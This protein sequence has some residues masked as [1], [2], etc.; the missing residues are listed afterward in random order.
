MNEILFRPW[1]LLV[2]GRIWTG[3][4]KGATLAN[5]RSA[6]KNWLEGARTSEQDEQLAPSLE[7]LE[8]AGYCES[9][10]KGKTT[11]WHIT[12]KGAEALRHRLHLPASAKAPTWAKLLA[13]PIMAAAA[14]VA[15]QTE[16]DWKRIQSAGG[17]RAMLLRRAHDLPVRDIPTAKEAGDALLWKQLGVETDR[18]FSMEAV[19]R[20]L[21][22][23]ALGQ[24][25][26]SLTSTKLMALL[27]GKAAGARRNDV[28]AMREAMVKNWLEGTAPAREKAPEVNGTGGLETFAE[29][30]MEAVNQT[31]TG[32]FGDYL[33]FIH[34]VYATYRSRFAGEDVPLCDFKDKLVEAHRD[35]AIAL[36]RADLVSAMPPDDIALSETRYLN[37]TFH[38]IRLPHGDV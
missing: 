36:A 19:K 4:E 27:A 29:K 33:V 10:T 7:A 15:P 32:W 3:G 5:L 35:G 34:H 6:L 14:G 18:P 28:R 16:A 38:F 37:A 31:A 1:P 22:R 23:R 12:E 17:L 8:N 21:L 24:D 25:A 13:G 2:L 26:G 20:H 30:V 9:H 11:R